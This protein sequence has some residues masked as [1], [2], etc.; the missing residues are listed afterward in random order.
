MSMN[1]KHIWL[2]YLPA[3]QLWGKAVAVLNKMFL[4]GSTFYR[5]I[6]PGYATIYQAVRERIYPQAYETFHGAISSCL[7]PDGE[8]L[9]LGCGVGAN[10]TCLKT[11]Q[12]PLGSYTGVDLTDAMLQRAQERYGNLPNVS[13][14]QLD[15]M[16]DPLPEGPYDLIISTWVFE[17][18]PDP[19]KVADKAW[20]KLRPGRQMVLLIK[21]QARSIVNQVTDTIYSLIGAH[22]IKENEY[23]QF[24]GQVMVEE[25]F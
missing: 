6:A 14:K 11:L 10:L 25:H 18:L 5:L 7:V 23:R 1:G 4:D 8:V 19:V 24:P 20:E 3:W 2:L 16:T 9:D 17:H 15:L 22:C 21:T 12:L 13:F